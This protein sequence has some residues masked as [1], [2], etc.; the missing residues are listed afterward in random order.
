M[1]PIRRPR[2]Q[3]G[4]SLFDGVVSLCLLA[5]GLV[6]VVR[7]QTNLTVQGGEALQR[8]IASRMA[9]E[10]LNSMLVDAENAACYTLPATGVCPSAAARNVADAWKVRALAALP[11]TVTATSAINAGTSRMT[12][13][14]T[15][16]FK[17]AAEP[18]T[19]E[20]SSDI[21]L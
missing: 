1:R 7:F 9:D 6:S 17:D 5:F 18:R 10:L 20:V 14:L 3:R 19:H 13:R 16:H 15:W 8:Q 12:V 2:P 11:G 4:F 21:R